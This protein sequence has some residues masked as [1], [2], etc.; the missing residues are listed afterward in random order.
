MYQIA[1]L[2]TN[3]ITLAPSRTIKIFDFLKNVRLPKDCTGGAKGTSHS[4]LTLDHH[5]EHPGLLL[6]ML[7]IFILLEGDPV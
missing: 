6:L 4:H 7:I 1:P 5:C 2:E 3:L